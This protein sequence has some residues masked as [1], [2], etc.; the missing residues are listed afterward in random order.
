MKVSRTC[1]RSLRGNI[2]KLTK[3]FLSF[4]GLFVPFGTFWTYQTFL[5]EALHDP[6]VQ[7]VQK[8]KKSQTCLQ[9]V[10]KVEKVHIT[11]IK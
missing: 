8:G 4:Y 7:K 1:S 6:K 10:K 3:Y 2:R 5:G 11:N 9:K